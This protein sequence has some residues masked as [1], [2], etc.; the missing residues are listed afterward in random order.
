MIN[1]FKHH[2][3]ELCI[4]VYR[5]AIEVLEGKTANQFK[6]RV[7]AEDPATLSS[8]HGLHI[9]S[10]DRN[11]HGVTA[12]SLENIFINLD[13]PAFLKW[14]CPM[15]APSAYALPPPPLQ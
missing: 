11:M 15:N 6:I 2:P 8:F 10:T 9:S 7:I 13:V 4:Q 1:I 3:P 5:D 12:P 14:L